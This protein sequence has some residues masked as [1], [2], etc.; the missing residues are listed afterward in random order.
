MLW[1][2]KWPKK[3]RALR[4]AL[5]N[6]WPWQ[7][8]SGALRS[9]PTPAAD[10]L[11]SLVWSFL[12]ILEKLRGVGGGGTSLRICQLLDRRFETSPIH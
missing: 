12:V 2:Q 9:S 10:K 6:A 1:R 7:V 8:P 4:D 5:C 3:G 11:A